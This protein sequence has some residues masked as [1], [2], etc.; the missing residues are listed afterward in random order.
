MRAIAEFKAYISR[1][2]SLSEMKYIFNKTKLTVSGKDAKT[3]MKAFFI[4][5]YD[6]IWTTGEPKGLFSGLKLKNGDL[7][8]R[9]ARFEKY[10]SEI[11]SDNS[12]FDFVDSI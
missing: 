6:T 3:Q 12:L 8:D 11:D 7:V 9:P 4:K 1:I 10:L 5:N 2:N